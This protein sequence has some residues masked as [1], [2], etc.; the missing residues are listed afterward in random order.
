MAL[1]ALAAVHAVVLGAEETAEHVPLAAAH[2]PARWHASGDVHT[3][4]G[5]ATHAPALQVSGL[6]QALLSALHDVPSALFAYAHIPEA[7]LQVPSPWHCVAVGQMTAAPGMHTPAAQVSP[8]VHA[9][10]SLQAPPVVGA[11]VPVAAEQAVQ[12]VQVVAS[13]CH[14]PL[15]PHVCGCTT[16][17]H[18]LDPGVQ[19]P[20]HAPL[21]GSHRNVHAFPVLCHWPLAL[22][23]CGCIPLH[24]MAFGAHTPVQACVLASHAN[25]QAAP[26]FCQRPA[27]LQVW[28]CR[29]LHCVAPAA[30]VAQVPALQTLGH[31]AV[32]DC[33][34]PDAEHVCGRRPLHC[35]EPGVHTPLQLP[36]LQTTGHALPM[37]CHSPLLSQV[38][39]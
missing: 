30:H 31:G 4:A 22:Q 1:V 9:L 12:P 18:C 35:V 21:A 26:V 37:S 13:F 6:V 25:G 23:V 7:A 24:P 3:T 36:A 33:H 34:W 27:A 11:Q 17:L 29:P 28:G 16:P 32:A 20:V 2:V 39:G 15:A 8:W 38:C 10:P 19:I 5:P 14:S